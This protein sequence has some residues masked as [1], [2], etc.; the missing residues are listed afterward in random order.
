[1]KSSPDRVHPLW[2]EF[3]QDLEPVSGSD[4]LS[5]LQDKYLGRKRGLISLE[6]RKLGALTPQERSEAGQQLNELKAQVQAELSERLAKFKEEERRLQLATERID[7]TLP[8]YEAARG[9]IHP[10]AAPLCGCLEINIISAN[11]SSG[12]DL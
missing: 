12:N 7:V 10:H 6:L 2:D 5:D 3:C 11:T 8:G 4:E 1:M 9:G